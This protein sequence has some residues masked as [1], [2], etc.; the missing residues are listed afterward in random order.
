MLDIRIKSEH[1]QLAE[2]LMEKY[3]DY[4]S[5]MLLDEIA[6]CVETSGIDYKKKIDGDSPIKFSIDYDKSFK[7]HKDLMFTVNVPYEDT[8]GEQFKDY[9]IL[10]DKDSEE[11]EEITEDDKV[12]LCLLFM[13]YVYYKTIDG[14]FSDSSIIEDFDV[15]YQ[16]ALHSRIYPEIFSLYKMILESKA[17]NSKG[18]TISI[19]HED[20]KK[21]IKVNACSWFIDDMEK[22]FAN[23]FPNLTLGKIDNYLFRLKGKAGR[24][25][26][27]H[28]TTNIIWGTYHLL[29]NHHSK[30]KDSETK[31]SNEICYFIIDYLNYLGVEHDYVEAFEIKDI[32]RH[33]L[34]H[35]YVPKWTAEWDVL[36]LDTFEKPKTLEEML[37]SP[38]R[39]YDINS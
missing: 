15:E 11:K 28:Y 12:Y 10:L 7:E 31:I 37:K 33:H 35:Q 9:F 13:S 14:L 29:H 2:P 39:R 1:L 19:I 27:D 6:S 26:L 22:Y 38:L 30:F 23:R 3:Y 25:H 34:R 8:I 4:H 17:Q 5:S 21:K 18:S 36:F 32:L 20:T 16:S 24:K